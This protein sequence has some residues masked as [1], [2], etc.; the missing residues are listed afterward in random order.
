MSAAI[1][2]ATPEAIRIEP[3]RTAVVI[4]D[5]QNA[6][7]SPG[8]YLDLIGFDVSRVRP[9][10]DAV[11]RVVDAARKA[12]IPVF[13]GQNGFRADYADAPSQAPIWHKS[14]ALRYMR[15]HP[16]RHGTILT[17]GTWDYDFIDELRPVEGEQV[18]R[19]S[20]ASCFAGTAL[21]QLLRAH[22]IRHVVVV[23]IALNVGVEWTLR[24]AMSRE[25]HA[26]LIRDATMAAGGKSIYDASIFNIETFIGWAAHSSDWVRALS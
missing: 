22:D 13:H 6:F 14:P 17:E 21:E 9:V 7:C 19:K 3:D 25:F 10:I 23:G 18:L 5:M 2:S 20:R 26:V 8:G 1:L 4:N 16:D 11:I 12:G 15:G 24:E